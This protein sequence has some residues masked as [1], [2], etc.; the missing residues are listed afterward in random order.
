MELTK[1]EHACFTVE[2]DGKSIIVDP[3]SFT[4]DL[5]IPNNVVAIVVTH[6]HGDHFNEELLAEIIAKNGA[7]LVIGPQAVTSQLSGYETRTVHGGDSFAIEGFDL[8]FYGDNHAVIHPSIPVVQNV[9]VLI[10]DRLYYP[11]DSFTIPEKSVDTLA[12]P[13][14]AP[15]L[16]IA[17][18][19][20]FMKS[21]GA[22]F[23]FPTHDAILSTAG[24]YIVDNIVSGFAEAVGTEYKRIDGETIEIE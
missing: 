11:G 6:D 12:L 9:G 15:W 24:K 19:I 17:E 21:V 3:G 22:R 23:T 5:T 8:D 2:K 13:V 18:T 20:E 16:K 1:Y 10:E 7:A 4:T 14:A